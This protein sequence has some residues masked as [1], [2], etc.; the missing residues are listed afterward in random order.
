MDDAKAEE[1]N[2]VAA[3]GNERYV[4]SLKYMCMMLLFEIHTDVELIYIFYP[5]DRFSCVFNLSSF[6]W[7]SLYHETKQMTK[8]IQDRRFYTNSARSQVLRA[9]VTYFF[10]VRRKII[11]FRSIQL[12]LSC[13]RQRST[14]RLL[15]VSSFELLFVLF[16]C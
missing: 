13:A 10:V 7:K 11:M 5:Y 8:M 16:F 12:I 14:T 4:C 15:M 3:I 6:G 2:L 9:F 1:V